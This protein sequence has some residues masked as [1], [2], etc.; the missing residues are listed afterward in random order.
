MEI[1]K[2]NKT[3]LEVNADYGDYEYLLMPDVHFDNPKCKRD[4]FF[5]WMDQAKE[6][7]AKVMFFGDFFCL[8]EGRYDPRRSRTGIRPE[9]NKNSY[10]DLVI[11]D[12]AEQLM[13]Y[14]DNILFFGEG[15]HEN[16][17]RLN[18]D[19]D[20]LQRLTERINM[21]TGSNIVKFGY[22]GFV[23]FKY[24]QP[25][26]QTGTITKVLYFHHGRYGGTI[27]KG[28]IGTMRHGAVTPDADIVVTGH[29]HDHWSMEIPRYRVS[30]LTGDVRIDTQLHLKVGT[31]KEEFAH[32]DGW[33]VEKIVMPKSIKGWWLRHSYSQSLKQKKTKDVHISYEPTS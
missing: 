12:A 30:N 28:T 23:L 1:K 18:L 11:N 14:A 17:V 3:T 31:L 13:P 19:T 21:A 22:S 16:K 29:T 33:A 32:M 6:R 24:K 27:T 8:M 10:L 5:R 20:P 9:Y 15:N 4:I 7:N 25:K 26:E 2:P